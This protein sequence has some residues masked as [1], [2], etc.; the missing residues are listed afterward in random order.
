MFT[1]EKTRAINVG[2]VQ[3]GGQSN[4]IVQSM[5]N[6]HTYDKDATIQQIKELVDA[7]AELVRI[8]VPDAKSLAQ[9]ESIVA[10]SSV[11]LVADIHFDYKLAIGAMEAGIAKVRIN[12]GNI[13]GQDK[14]LEV[15]N[16]AK[17]YEVPIRIGVNHGSIGA[18]EDKIKLSLKVL[19]EYVTFFEKNDFWDL[20]ISLKSSDVM[21]SVIMNEIFAKRHDYPLHLGITEAGY[22]DAGLIKSSA[23][24]GAML[25][26]GLG[27]TIRVSLTGNPVKEIPVAKSLLRSV[28]LLKEGVEIISCPTCGRT[29]IDLESLAKQVGEKLKNIKI[30]LK[31]AVMGCVVNGPGEAA[32]A[33]YAICGAKEVGYIY[34]DGNQLKKVPEKALVEEL[35]KIINED[36]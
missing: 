30:P 22:G 10:G 3:I 13:G 14:L 27:D 28:G 15:I 21:S 24:I 19:E 33:D 8:A 25:L 23:G 29:E 34:K 20:V 4:V 5:T 11:P 9:V 26:K 7:G 36:Q 2:G 17:Q 16:A 12:P 1:R 6:T 31:V 18:A 35:L 32:D